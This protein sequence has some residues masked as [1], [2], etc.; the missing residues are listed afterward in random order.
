MASAAAAGTVAGTTSLREG[1]EGRGG[2]A[3]A[4]ESEAPA[5]TQRRRELQ[6]RKVEARR[7]LLN[8]DLS[9]LPTGQRLAVTLGVLLIAAALMAGVAWLVGLIG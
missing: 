1:R 6:F 3:A 7:G 2:A 9:Q 8:A 5:L 4:R